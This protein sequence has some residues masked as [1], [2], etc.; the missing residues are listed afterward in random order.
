MTEAEYVTVIE[1]CKEL[2]WQ[3]DFLKEL[4]KK[5]KAQ[6]LHSDSQSMIDL[7][8]NPVYHDRK[9]HI[10]VWYHFIR[11]LL[12][13]GVFSPLKIHMSQN[14]VDMLTKVVTMEKL[15]SCSASMGLQA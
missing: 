5:K 9:K 13:D 8:N 2:I 1:A 14:P 10:D 11:K 4:R 7:A 3:K 12:E 6:S 15:K